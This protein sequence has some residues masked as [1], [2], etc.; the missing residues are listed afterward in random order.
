MEEVLSRM[1]GVIRGDLLI[2]SIP[3]LQ[4]DYHFPQVPSGLESRPAGAN[5]P[6]RWK[7]TYKFSKVAL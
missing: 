2:A 4:W 6:G 7:G 1:L 5:R 3:Q